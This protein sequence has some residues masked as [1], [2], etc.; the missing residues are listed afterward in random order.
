MAYTHAGESRIASGGGRLIMT[1]K[2]KARETGESLVGILRSYL[3]LYFIFILIALL[4]GT[5]A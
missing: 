1:G 2:E 3:A 4:L 5:C